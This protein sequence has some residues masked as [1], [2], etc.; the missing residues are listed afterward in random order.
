MPNLRF[1][2]FKAYSNL[3]KLAESDI[4]R[5]R[6]T[7]NVESL[8]HVTWG[9]RYYDMMNNE[10]SR[11]TYILEVAQKLMGYVTISFKAGGVLA[12]DEVAVDKS[13]PNGAYYF[14][15]LARWAETCG[16]HAAC[17]QIEMWALEARVSAFKRFG[18]HPAEGKSMVIDG[19]TYIYM[20]KVLLYHI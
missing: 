11:I 16:R 7:S 15:I 19:E 14:T 18:C 5:P 13:C 17:N 3:R 20:T 6:V 8:D 4:K 10:G 9:D 12:I 1:H 2:K